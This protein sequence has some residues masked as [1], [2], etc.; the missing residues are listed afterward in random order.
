[1]RSKRSSVSRKGRVDATILDRAA[2]DGA[3][4]KFAGAALP[5]DPAILDGRRSFSRCRPEE[6]AR[7]LDSSLAGSCSWNLSHDA[8]R[9]SKRA[10][11][12]PFAS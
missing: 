8:I 2:L 10:N 1:M 5:A 4:S 11:L 12:T 6:I 9:L 3:E 7:H